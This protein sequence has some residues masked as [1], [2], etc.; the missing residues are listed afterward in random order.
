[1]SVLPQ[2]IEC[3]STDGITIGLIDAIITLAVVLNERLE[4]QAK[5]M[6]RSPDEYEWFSEDVRN[7]LCD[8]AGNP[9]VKRLLFPRDEKAMA[10]IHEA[11]RSLTGHG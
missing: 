4:K 9:A 1:V 2:T 10:I 11:A 7:A 5:R 3:T 8:L 6:K